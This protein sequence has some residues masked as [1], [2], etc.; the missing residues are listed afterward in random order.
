VAGA[1]SYEYAVN[2][3]ATPPATGTFTTA[4]SVTVNSL[5]PGTKYYFHVRARCGA[6]NYSPWATSNFTT[7]VAGSCN[8]P[9][10]LTVTN[11]SASGA[12][13]AWASQSGILAYEY[14]VKTSPVPPTSGS[15]VTT[16]SASASGLASNTDYYLF[17]RAKCNATVNSGWSTKLFHTAVSTGVGKLDNE[18]IHIE[19]FPNPVRDKLSVKLS[20]GS[21]N[22][23]VTLVDLSGKLVCSYTIDGTETEIDLANLSAG[24]YFLKFQSSKASTAL[25]IIKQ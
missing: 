9:A 20:Q 10:T 4:T 12:S 14:V 16:T 1:V 19:I 2:T 17:V 24:T 5:L 11:I 22:G 21:P 7:N 6:T 3:S 8:A 18:G 15:V 13:L 25:R 23:K